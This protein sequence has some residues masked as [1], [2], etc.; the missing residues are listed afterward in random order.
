LFIN[1][2]KTEKHEIVAASVK[3]AI[4]SEETIRI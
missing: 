2:T 1:V 4:K 3:E